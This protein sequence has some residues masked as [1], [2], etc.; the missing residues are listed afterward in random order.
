MARIV[1]PNEPKVTAKRD[2]KPPSGETMA[3]RKAKAGDLV[4]SG[5]MMLQRT[6]G[7]RKAT[8]VR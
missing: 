8:G 4:Q 5:E 1:G 7:R 3:T 2:E 6:L